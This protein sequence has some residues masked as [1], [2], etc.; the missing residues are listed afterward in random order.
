MQTVTLGKTGLRISRMGFGGIPLQRVSK[1]DAREIFLSLRS[2]GINFIDTARGYTVSEEY[3]GSAVKGMREQFVLATKSRAVTKSDMERDILISLQSL[4]TDYIDLYQLHNP[5]MY[6]FDEICE[7]NGALEALL[8]AK[9]RGKIGHIGITAHS[10]EVFA[11]ALEL[12]WVETVMFPYNIIETQGEELIKK[13]KDKNIGFIDMKPFAGG[14]I[15]NAN[16]AL[17]F[18]CSNEN[19]TV[20]IPG[21]YAV[22]EIAENIASVENTEPLTD[23]ELEEIERI[24]RILGNQFC[25]RC[26]YCAPCV[27]GISIPDVLLFEGYLERYGLEKWA[28]ERYASLSVKASACIGCGICES[29]CPYNLPVRDM[30]RR[31]AR[32]FGE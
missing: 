24:R 6:Q 18:V 30:V 11:R 16:L 14:A 26:N 15:E 13:C 9:E 8:D 20:T 7:E 10:L 27:R 22:K 21:M 32:N 5:N 25:R 2:K 28:R 31:S 12:P 17:R 23:A 19:V 1:E 29:R 4:Q 3:I